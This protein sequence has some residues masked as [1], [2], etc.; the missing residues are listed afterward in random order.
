MGGSCSQRG[1]LVVSGLFLCPGATTVKKR[2]P[3]AF[4]EPTVSR[5]RQTLKQ[6][7]SARCGECSGG[8][9]CLPDKG[10]ASEIRE[11]FLREMTQELNLK[12]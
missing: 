11:G 6:L 5:E 2:N 1:L 9:S 7:N 12:V 8:E 3:P 10:Q 4:K